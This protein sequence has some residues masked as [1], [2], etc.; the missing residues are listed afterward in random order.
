MDEQTQKCLLGILQRGIAEARSCALV[1]ENKKAANLLDALDNIPR[2]LANWTPN[3]ELEIIM[4]LETFGKQHPDH[5]TDFAAIFRQ[6][7]QVLY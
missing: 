5:A 7:R 1:G 4:Q 2:H 6:R 3:A